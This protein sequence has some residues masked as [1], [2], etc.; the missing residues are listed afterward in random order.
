MM[1]TSLSADAASAAKHGCPKGGSCCVFYR[2][3]TEIGG[4]EVSPYAFTEQVVLGFSCFLLLWHLHK[5]YAAAY[6]LQFRPL[7]DLSGSGSHV[8][9]TGGR[10]PGRRSRTRM[11]LPEYFGI[12]IFVC[13]LFVVTTAVFRVQHLSTHGDAANVAAYM[14]YAFYAMIDNYVLAFLCFEPP[15]LLASA[16]GRRRAARWFL[17]PAAVAA[18]AS[19]LIY[20]IY[21]S[22][23]TTK[24]TCAWC[25]IHFPKPGIEFAYAAQTALFVAAAL[26][27]KRGKRVCGKRIRLRPAVLYWSVFEAVA[28]GLAAIGLAILHFSGHD[29][30]YCFLLLALAD[31]SFLYAP[32][33]VEILSAETLFQIERRCIAQLRPW[34]L[35]L[36]ECSLRDCMTGCTS[37]PRAIRPSAGA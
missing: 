25:G 14:S 5:S 24:A 7:S 31:Y 17:Q 18:I 16:G 12:V 8:S 6:S 11:V 33:P 4:A 34:I 37:S 27:A 28:Y 36:A 15:S 35:I 23:L 2:S 10:P 29:S 20:L 3:R 22:S 9:A 30:G 1:N 32:L 21:V 13:V 26:L 19:F